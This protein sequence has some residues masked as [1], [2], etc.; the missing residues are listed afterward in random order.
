MPYE[1][2]GVFFR[3]LGVRVGSK[4]VIFAAAERLPNTSAKPDSAAALKAISKGKNI[5][6]GY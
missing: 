5:G 4:M 2:S 6:Y 1:F 3:L